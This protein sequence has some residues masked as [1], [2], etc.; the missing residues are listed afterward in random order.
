MNRDLIKI[1]MSECVNVLVS[2]A[3]FFYYEHCMIHIAR[4]QT[5]AVYQLHFR[6]LMSAV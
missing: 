6:V 2:C 1:G 5:I 4:V 3:F